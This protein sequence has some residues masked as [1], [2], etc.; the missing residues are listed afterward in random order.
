MEETNFASDADN[1][2]RKSPFG[3]SIIMVIV[4]FLVL[5]GWGFMKW[6]IQTLD[7]SINQTADRF[8]EVSKSFHG[9]SVDRVN[10]FEKR[11]DIAK[12]EKDK[13]DN[14][15][16]D[17]LAKLEELTLPEVRIKKYEVNME[18]KTIQVTGITNS[19]RYTAEQIAQF[20]TDPFFHSVT[21][22]NFSKDEAGI[23]TFTFDVTF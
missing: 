15:P 17:F 8:N 12:T 6:Y 23:I 3:A 22:S 2:K 11:L 4:F 18:K 7:T 13:K 9:A 14:M 19:F 10:A 5:A 21:V 1:R 16:N 20:K